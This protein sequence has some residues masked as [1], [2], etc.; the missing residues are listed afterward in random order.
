MT[1]HELKAQRALQKFILEI[2][3]RQKVTDH[4]HY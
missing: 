2:D 1:V 3:T 4:Q